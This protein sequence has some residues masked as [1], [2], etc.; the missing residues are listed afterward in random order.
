MSHFLQKSLKIAPEKIRNINHRLY[1][2]FVYTSATL[3]QC[4]SKCIFLIDESRLFVSKH[5]SLLKY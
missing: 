4:S 3:C 2:T 5:F 1:T